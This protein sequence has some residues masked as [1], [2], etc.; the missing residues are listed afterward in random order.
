VLRRRFSSFAQV[1]VGFAKFQV[2]TCQEVRAH[3]A[4]DFLVEIPP[5]A[6]HQVFEGPRLCRPT[7]RRQLTCS[8]G[9]VSTHREHAAEKHSIRCML[10]RVIF[11]SERA[12]CDRRPMPYRH[13]TTM[14]PHLVRQNLQQGRLGPM[15]A[16]DDA[17]ALQGT[18]T[19]GRLDTSTHRY[20]GLSYNTGPVILQ[21]FPWRSRHSIPQSHDGFTT[22]T[23]IHDL[24]SLEP[25]A[26][27]A[28]HTQNMRQL[29]ALSQHFNFPLHRIPLLISLS[30][31]SLARPTRS[32]VVPSSRPV[33]TYI[34]QAT[35]CELAPLMSQISN[36]HPAT[37][38]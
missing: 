16:M 33:C 32:P 7:T 1:G 2:L 28:N 19:V 23:R 22:I 17:G 9:P 24:A 13:T 20:T 27:L 10:L 5:H 26:R 18:I 37:L 8:H 34:Y 25:L 14:R 35:E 38:S 31:P 29:D 6:E 11:A 30:A 4:H 12:I 21:I 3:S 15:N 36:V